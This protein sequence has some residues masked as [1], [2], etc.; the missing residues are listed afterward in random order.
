M[1]TSKTDIK[2][3]AVTS[4][5]AV[6]CNLGECYSFIILTQDKYCHNGDAIYNF[7]HKELISEPHIS[8]TLKRQDT[9]LSL[10]RAE[11]EKVG[12]SKMS[13]LRITINGVVPTRT[14]SSS[15]I[16]ALL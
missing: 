10:S 9:V 16:C 7:P 1:A 5:C 3:T 11:P 6:Y 15:V 14:S 4:R 8:V 2:Q 12:N 13:Y